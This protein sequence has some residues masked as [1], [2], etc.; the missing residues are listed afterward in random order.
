MMM[1]WILLS[2]CNL[3]LTNLIA[4]RSPWYTQ[5]RQKVHF[6]AEN[7]SFITWT[8]KF[9]TLYSLCIQICVC[10]LGARTECE[11]YLRMHVYETLT[12]SWKRR[13]HMDEGKVSLPCWTNIFQ[14]III[15]IQV[16]WF[17]FADN[18]TNVSQPSIMHTTNNFNTTCS[19]GAMCCSKDPRFCCKGFVEVFVRLNV[20]TMNVHTPVALDA[21]SCFHVHDG[22]HTHVLTNNDNLVTVYNITYK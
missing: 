11:S 8:V 19:N 22:K 9:A 5:I 14:I 6:Q 13:G 17:C 1:P 12:S 20:H 10:L 4:C 21:Y 2:L 7:Q 18:C 3:I 15:G 16:S